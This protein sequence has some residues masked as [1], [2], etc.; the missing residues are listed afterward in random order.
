MHATDTGETTGR[1]P[2]ARATV[3]R[4][5]L[6]VLVTAA[7]LGV[8]AWQYDAPLPGRGRAVPRAPGSAAWTLGAYAACLL[9]VTAALRFRNAF[10]IGGAE[11]DIRAGL[12]IVLGTLLPVMHRYGHDYFAER[13]YN[14]LFWFFC[15]PLAVVVLVYGEPPTRYGLR[16]GHWREGL[17]WTAVGV[18]LMAPILWYLGHKSP[19]MQR[20]YQMMGGTR[21]VP[22]ILWSWGVEMFA[23]EYIWRGFY[24]FALLRVMGPGP[25]ILLQAVPFAFM[26]LGKPELEVLSTPFGGAAFGFI[27]WRTGAFWPAFLVHWFMIVFL[28]LA[29]TGRV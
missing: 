4:A 2:S 10:R 22:A 20:Y 1:L 9:G 7:F 5:I 14:Q 6:L 18:A 12:A 16:L 24:L 19:E 28:E 11:V 25:A 3:I 26:H 27:A 23:W 29:A 17:V 15:V 13:A 21:P 8:Y